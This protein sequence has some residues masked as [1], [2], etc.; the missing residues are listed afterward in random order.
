LD[1]GE[2]DIYLD[3]EGHPGYESD[4]VGTVTCEGLALDVWEHELFFTGRDRSQNF[5]MQAGRVPSL[6]AERILRRLQ[7]LQTV[8]QDIG[9]NRPKDYEELLEFTGD[10]G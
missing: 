10:F 4:N 6:S 2:D 5:L 9:L 7:E 3:A 8:G 1:A